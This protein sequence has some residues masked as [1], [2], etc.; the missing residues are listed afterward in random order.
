MNLR[1]MSYLLA[2]A[3]SQASGALPDIPQPAVPECSLSAGGGQVDFGRSSPAQLRPTAG[4]MT[5]GVRRLMVIVSC[6]LAQE[7][8]LRAAGP[9]SGAAFRWGEGGGTLRIHIAR[10]LLDGDDVQL[11]R[12]LAGDSRTGDAVSRLQL[13]PGEGI[14]VLRQGA[15]ARGRLLTLSLTL[16]PLL[17][18]QESHPRQRVRTDGWLDLTLLP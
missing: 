18:G 9:A 15:P 7:M 3:L 17:S 2:L 5:P 4:V 10:A 6:T 16:E 12:I 8:R 1:M 14:V 11:A 13:R